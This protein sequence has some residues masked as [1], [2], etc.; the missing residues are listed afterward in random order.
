MAWIPEQTDLEHKDSDLAI[1]HLISYEPGVSEVVSSYQW[2]LQPEKPIQFEIAADGTGVTL[3]VAPF[4]GLFKPDY[5]DYWTPEGIKRVMSWDE[6][7]LGREIIEFKPTSTA[8]R[9]YQLEVIATVI[10]TRESTRY[11]EE[12]NQRFNIVVSHDY[13]EGKRRLQE[14]ML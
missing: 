7:P 5:I 3:K 1:E 10:K 11:T 2:T 14:Y 13:D 6:M 4:S 8:S 12:R 9:I